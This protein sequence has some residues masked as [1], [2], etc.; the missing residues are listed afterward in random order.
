MI[1]GLSFVLFLYSGLPSRMV[2]G[3]HV[4]EL[5]TVALD[6]LHQVSF[7]EVPHRENMKIKIRIGIHTG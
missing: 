5:A 1:V 7:L 4:S 6:L 3:M 2:G